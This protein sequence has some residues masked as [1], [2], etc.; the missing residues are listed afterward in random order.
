MG[1]AL[2]VT[3]DP[4]AVVVPGARIADHAPRAHVAI[5]AVD[6]IGEESL[7]R[8]S[9][10]QLEKRPPVDAVQLG[11]TAFEPANDGVLVRVAE[12]NERAAFFSLAILVERRQRFA[13][14]HRRAVFVLRA[15]LLGF[16]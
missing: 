7:S 13:I 2:V 4:V 10:Q 5:A 1:I 9:E 11:G 16:F 8:V 15:L 14:T 12:G 3:V 6:R